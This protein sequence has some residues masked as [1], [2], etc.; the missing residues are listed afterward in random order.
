MK[1]LIAG[2]RG[3]I[4]THEGGVH[5]II[6]D[7]VE[8]YRLDVTEVVHGG[9]RGI[10]LMGGRWANKRD[11][12]VVEMV[13]EWTKGKQA[14][15]VRNGKMVEYCDFAMV[16][17]DGHSKGTEDTARKMIKSGKP[18]WLMRWAWITDYRG[19]KQPKALIVDP[20]GS[21]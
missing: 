17:W 14:G 3:I 16:F 8:K 9:A 10:D 7:L 18:L 4:K 13:P 15:L 12:P 19:P 11:L 20:F 6:S 5:H 21:A 2:S 1:L